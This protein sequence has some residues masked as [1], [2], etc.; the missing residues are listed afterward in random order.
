MSVFSRRLARLASRVVLP[1]AAVGGLAGLSLAA[2]A[3][4]AAAPAAAHL[5]SVRVVP[6]IGHPV[7]G[8]ALTAPI[9]TSQCQAQIGIE[10]FSPVQYR[11][12]YDLNPLYSRGITGA[13]RTIVIVDSFGSPTIAH[14]IHVFDQQ[15]GSPILTCRS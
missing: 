4:T 15:W 1:V 9:S 11:V 12:A 3:V 7:L 13:G 14:D 6:A 10:C 2:P 8:K 5:T